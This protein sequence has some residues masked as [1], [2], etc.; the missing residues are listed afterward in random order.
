MLTRGPIQA[1][2]YPTAPGPQNGDECPAALDE[3][4]I[5][6]CLVSPGGLM[7]GLAAA[8]TAE[9]GSICGL[10]FSL[11]PAAPA[12][13][14]SDVKGRATCQSHLTQVWQDMVCRG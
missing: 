5:K 9:K 11:Q 1:A 3:M 6:G 10:S 14:N 13:P 7:H 8:V 4:P 12:T 2:G